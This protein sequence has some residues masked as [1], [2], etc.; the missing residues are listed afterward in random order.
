MSERRVVVTG[1]GLVTSLGNDLTTFWNNIL[2][3]VSGV[4]TLSKYFDPVKEGLSVTIGGE[5]P[6]LQGEFYSDRKMLRR[7]D[8][9]ITYAVYAAYHAMNQAGIKPRSGFDPTRAGAILGSGIG[10]MTTLLRE[11]SVILQD[12]PTRVSPFFVPMQIINMAPGVIAI[13]YGLQGPNYSVVTACAS[14]THAIGVGFKHIKDNEADIMLVGGSEATIN[15]LTI[16]GFSNARALSTRNSD[17]TKASRP[18]DKDRDG[19]VMSEG[20]AVLVLEEYEYAKKRGAN[21]LGEVLGYG[22]TCDANHITAPLDDGAMSGRAMKLA[23]EN[24]KLDAS[25]IDYINTHG[26]STPVGDIAEIKAIK[27]ALGDRAKKVKINSTKS[28]V[29][30]ALGG[31]GAIEAIATILQM[32]EG[33]IHPTI[34][35]ENQ[36]P[37][38]DLDCVA[39]TAEDYKIEYA[40]SNSLGFG[41]HNASVIFKKV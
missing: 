30:H 32:N 18:F 4:K 3:G 17:P 39:N 41:G 36:D 11:H 28:M 24:A 22:Y 25:K 26:T 6:E 23:L 9:F 16:A 37:E 27:V 15:T 34:N 21:I 33:K 19:F 5:V 20:G 12:G 38:C 35:I 40:M 13:E 8:P 7:F 1:M 31:A 29:G 2:N 14:S 10:G